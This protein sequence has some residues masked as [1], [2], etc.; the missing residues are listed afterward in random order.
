MA[1]EYPSTGSELTDLGLPPIAGLVVRSVVPGTP[2]EEAGFGD[3]PALVVE[4]DGVEM[5]A[6]LPGYC[7]A[8]EVRRSG[9]E[10]TYVTFFAGEAEPREIRVQYR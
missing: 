2:A 6:T 1:F 5:D 10:S 9:D 7:D 8:V 3:Q 4:V